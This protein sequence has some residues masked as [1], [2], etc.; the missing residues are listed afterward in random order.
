M[1]KNNIGEKIKQF[2]EMRMISRDDL[3]LNSN[4]DAEQ[5]R[6]I[7]EQGVVPSLGP[8]I[9]IARALGVRIGTFL[10]DAGQVGPVVVKAGSEKSTISFSSSDPSTRQHLNFFSLAA[11]KAGRH[12]EPFIVDIEPEQASDYKLSSHEGE[13]FIFVLQGCVEINYGR[14]LYRIEKGDCIYYD[15]IVSHNVHAGSAEPAKILAVIYTPY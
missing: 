7:E 4:L 3:A 2:R 14:D 9:R 5:L 12:M 6:V 15:S 11:D 13:E 1:Q 10:D 8:L